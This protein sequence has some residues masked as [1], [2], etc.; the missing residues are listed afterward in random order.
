VKSQKA[1]EQLNLHE[2]IKKLYYAAHWTPDRPVDA[3]KLWTDVRDA[4]GLPKGNSPEA[5]P[6][7]GI[8]TAY[9]VDR[10]RQIGHLVSAKKG[11][12]F[13]TTETRALLLLYGQ[14]LI[15]KL[16]ETVRKFL[17]EKLS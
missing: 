6:F 2:A 14:D 3:A 17:E 12:E 8:Q 4:A 9:S 16:D 10:I 7:D 11:K 5:I 13:G 15:D 1:M